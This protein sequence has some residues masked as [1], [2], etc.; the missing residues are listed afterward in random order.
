MPEPEPLPSPAEAPPPLPEGFVP[1]PRATWFETLLLCLVSNQLYVEVL[2]RWKGLGLVYLLLVLALLTLPCA[3][4]SHAVNYKRFQQLNELVV[5]QIPKITYR[6]GVATVEAQQ[7]YTI[8]KDGAK[9]AKEPWVYMDT[10]GEKVN[11]DSREEAL[12]VTRDSMFVRTRGASIRY[13]PVPHPFHGEFNASFAR[14]V[15]QLIMYGGG[16]ISYPMMIVD[17]FVMWTIHAALLAGLANFMMVGPRLGVKFADLFRMCIVACTPALYLNTIGF[18]A[19]TTNWELWTMI[20]AVVAV[21]YVTSGLR[22]AAEEVVA[23]G[24][25]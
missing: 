19:G 10:R 3:M 16:W 9:S 13:S 4:K 8:Y 21:M 17:G 23:E 7:P 2:R 22:A 20:L 12:V 5:P 25:K 6:E 11:L 14:V 1:P 15:C 18:L 24:E